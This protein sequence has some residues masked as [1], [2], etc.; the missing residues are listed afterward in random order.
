MLLS[1]W[2]P[3][4]G[5]QNINVCQTSFKDARVCQDKKYIYW[6]FF[7]TLKLLHASLPAGEIQSTLFL[8]HIL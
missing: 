6:S 3:A 5:R 7:I 8:L 1:G 2:Y 4:A